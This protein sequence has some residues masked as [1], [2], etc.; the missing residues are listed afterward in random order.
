MASPSSSAE[1]TEYD[2]YADGNGRQYGYLEM[3]KLSHP[4]TQTKK[5]SGNERL[6]DRTEL[7]M[8]LNDYDCLQN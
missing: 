6:D 5:R 3:S 7:R 2:G 1:T 8:H 4:R